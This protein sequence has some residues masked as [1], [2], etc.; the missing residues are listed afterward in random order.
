MSGDCPPA[1][2]TTV[3]AVGSAAQD[4][5][6]DGIRDL[7]G[8]LTEWTSSRYVPGN[9]APDPQGLGRDTPRVLR[10][11]SWA[12]SLRARSSGRGQYPPSQMGTNIGFRCASSTEDSRP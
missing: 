2:A 12:E 4:V 9:R 11:G 8:N 10:G 5:T 7:A 3:R 6:P 1:T